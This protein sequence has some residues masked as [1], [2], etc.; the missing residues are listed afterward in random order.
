[1]LAT[2]TFTRN[3]V[4]FVDG[5]SIPLLQATGDA[6]KLGALAARLK[7]DGDDMRTKLQRETDARVRAEL[8][9]SE[10]KATV[11]FEAKKCDAIMRTLQ[12]ELQ[13]DECE[14]EVLREQLM[15]MDAVRAERDH[16]KAEADFF[17][18]QLDARDVEL[19][20]IHEA[21]RMIELKL[22][23]SRRECALCE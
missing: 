11:A 10:L 20:R 18:E 23:E 22:K 1:M 4:P 16:W 19:C 12:L 15:A 5:A 14:C 7:A 17:S 21:L 13:R 6:E 2:P 8:M 3:S 9:V